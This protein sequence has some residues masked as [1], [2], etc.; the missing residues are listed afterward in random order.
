[1]HF[2]IRFM[3]LLLQN[4][5]DGNETNRQIIDYNKTC[6][7]CCKKHVNDVKRCACFLWNLEYQEKIANLYFQK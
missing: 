2:H 4:F 5:G 6:G 1:M 3:L 7:M